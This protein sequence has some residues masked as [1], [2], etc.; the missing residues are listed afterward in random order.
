M[1]DERKTDPHA[2]APDED[3]LKHLG[4]EIPDPW[5][6]DEQ[7]DWATRTVVVDDGEPD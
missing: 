5:D 2:A 4:E 3:P 6:D 7:T 1:T